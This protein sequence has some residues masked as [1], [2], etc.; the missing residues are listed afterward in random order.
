MRA[1]FGA[2]HSGIHPMGMKSEGQ[3]MGLAAAF[4]YGLQVMTSFLFYFF[5]TRMDLLSRSYA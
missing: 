1:L 5:I 4:A 2:D 3:Q